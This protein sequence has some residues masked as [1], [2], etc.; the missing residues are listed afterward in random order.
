MANNRLYIGS[1]SF[2]TTDSALKEAFEKFGPV[3]DCKVITDRDSGRSK[4]FGFVTFENEEDAKKAVDEM[5]DQELDGRRI[6]VDVSRP[7]EE[8]SDRGGSY[9]RSYDRDRGDRSY[10]RSYDRDRGDRDRGYDRDRNYH[11]DDRDRNDRERSHRHSQ[12]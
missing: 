12:D 8:R 7:R 6:R 10:N 11:R 2:S 3:S 9:N 1:L 5:N 4:G